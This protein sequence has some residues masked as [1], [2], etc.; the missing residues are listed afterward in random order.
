MRKKTSRAPKYIKLKEYLLAAINEGRLQ[1]GDCIGSENNLGSDFGISRP[2]VRNAIDELIKEGLVNRVPGKG[3]FVADPASRSFVQSSKVISFVVPD[4]QTPFIG[5][6][7]KGVQRVAEENG[8]ALAVYS[9]DWQIEKENRN[10]RLAMERGECGTII[11]PNWGRHNY[12][13]IL[14]LKKSGYPFVLIDRYF[15]DIPTDYVVVDNFMGAFEAVEYLIGLGHTSI[16]HVMG[17]P[18]TA[19]DARLE[20]YKQALLGKGLK[21]QEGNM[22]MIGSA[23][24]DQTEPHQACGYEETLELL[25]KKNRPTAIFAGS[26]FI[27][28]GVIQAAKSM[29][30]SVPDDIAVVGFDDLEFASWPD[31]ELTTVA[32]PKEDIG[33]IA[34]ELLIEKIEAKRKMREIQIQQIVL[35]PRLIARR[36]CGGVIAEKRGARSGQFATTA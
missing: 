36:T 22:L 21:V 15:R 2:S 18:G 3:T 26:D 29:G 33:A 31:I 10:I 34:A 27:A 1:P 4:V 20:G 23:E 24:E 5:P 32:Q 12:S 16:A 6:I 35:Q 13:E 7:Y 19:N 17:L 30:L 8:Y 14:E 28:L 11:F 9:S 25:Q